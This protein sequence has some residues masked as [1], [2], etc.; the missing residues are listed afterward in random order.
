VELREK[1][2]EENG[3]DKHIQEDHERLSMEPRAFQVA[4]DDGNMDV[5]VDPEEVT[6][7]FEGKK[8]FQ[9]V[10]GEE[11]YSIG[12]EETNKGE[13][14]FAFNFS[15]EETRHSMEENKV[16]ESPGAMED[17]PMSGEVEIKHVPK[18]VREAVSRF[19]EKAEK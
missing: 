19:K 17:K 7:E 15:H 6:V 2:S 12:E 5:E 18:I 4:V 11:K 3:D 14:S 8:T 16:R 10:K 9:D 1:D 13:R